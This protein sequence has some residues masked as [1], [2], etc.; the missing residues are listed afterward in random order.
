MSSAASR[1]ELPFDRGTTFY[2]LGNTPDLTLGPGGVNIEGRLYLAEPNNRKLG[3][4][5]GLDGRNV[6]LRVV[7]NRSAINLL[8]GRVVRAA[9]GTANESK[10]LYTGTDGYTWQTTDIILGVVDDQLPAAGVKPG[11]LFF[12]VEDGPTKVISV[13][14]GSPS[15]AAGA[16]IS[17]ATGTSAVSADAGFVTATNTSSTTALQLAANLGRAEA[18]L[19]ATITANSA[20]FQAVVRPRLV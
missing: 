3:S 7:R 20:P 6:V 1:G 9:L 16:E 10:N 14:T 11:D 5:G 13:T 19:A 17:P 2:G 12:V 18:N 4:V 15:I 8:P